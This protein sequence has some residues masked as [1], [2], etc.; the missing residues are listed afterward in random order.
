VSDATLRTLEQ[1]AL[2]TGAALD[3]ARHL[4]ERVRAGAVDPAQVRLAAFLGHA[5]ARELE[6]DAAPPRA[7]EAHV[8]RWAEEV[9]RCGGGGREVAARMALAA[10]GAAASAWSGAQGAEEESMLSSLQATRAW[11]TCPCLA[12]A[13]HAERAARSLLS[14]SMLSALMRSLAP[15]IAGL[16]PLLPAQTEVRAAHAGNAACK[17]AEVLRVPGYAA[18]AGAAATHASRATSAGRVRQA[19]RAELVAWALGSEPPS[20]GG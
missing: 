5:G 15:T 3:A 19:V 18:A 8:G 12:C 7:L 17:A 10:A 2:R 11:V 6:P 14:W 1:Q 9:V 16:P 4:R 20:S 13:D